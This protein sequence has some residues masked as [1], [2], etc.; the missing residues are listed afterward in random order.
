MV[1][2]APTQRRQPVSY[3]ELQE[4]LRTGSFPLMTDP[5]K[6]GKKPFCHNCVHWKRRDGF[7][8]TCRNKAAREFAL[9]AKLEYASEKPER[10]T[11]GSACVCPLHAFNPEP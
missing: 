5:V 3:P 6:P 9:F 2:Q 4:V 1:D 11:T 7:V 8:G 10:Y